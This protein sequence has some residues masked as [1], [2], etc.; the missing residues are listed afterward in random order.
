MSYDTG[1][2]KAKRQ[3]EEEE[4]NTDVVTKEDLNPEKLAKM[5][6]EILPNKDGPTKK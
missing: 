2:V 6:Y 3:I 5:P 4:K 1:K